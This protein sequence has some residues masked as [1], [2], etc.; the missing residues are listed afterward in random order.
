MFP[1]K[2]CFKKDKKKIGH[3]ARKRDMM[4]Q[5]YGIYAFNGTS[6]ARLTLQFTAAEKRFIE[7]IPEKH[8]NCKR[9]SQEYRTFPYLIY[10]EIKHFQ[11]TVILNVPRV[12]V[13]K[14]IICI[15]N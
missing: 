12:A 10:E 15:I 4:R 13:F 3:H 9:E 2:N 14:I 7:V 8:L 6:H 5:S 1:T 11:T